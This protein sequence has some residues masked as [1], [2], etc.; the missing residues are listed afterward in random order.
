MCNPI[1]FHE[2]YLGRLTAG[3]V[4]L[5]MVIGLSGCGGS[6]E[7]IV[8]ITPTNAPEIKESR[9]GWGIQFGSYAT[10][11]LASNEDVEVIYDDKGSVAKV[12]LNGRSF[13]CTGDKKPDECRTISGGLIQLSKL[14]IIGFSYLNSLNWMRRPYQYI[15]SHGDELLVTGKTTDRTQT[16]PTKGKAHYEGSMGAYLGTSDEITIFGGLVHLEADFAKGKVTGRLDNF[17]NEN[18]KTSLK[19]SLEVRNGKLNGNTL[20]ADIAGSVDGHEIDSKWT[21]MN[22]GFFGPNADEVGGGIAGKTKDNKN[23]NAIW[24]AKRQ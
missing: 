21:Q 1:F 23:F 14:D 17:K 24:W 6:S 2:E 13:V 20:T 19:G 10:G 8:N 5:G 3:I 22:G 4:A 18:T 7:E 15:P 9:K 11:R 16:M 12:I